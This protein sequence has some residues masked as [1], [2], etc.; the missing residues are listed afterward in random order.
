MYFNEFIGLINTRKGQFTEGNV[1][2]ILSEFF[3][4]E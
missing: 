3:S 2:K 1:F 4:N